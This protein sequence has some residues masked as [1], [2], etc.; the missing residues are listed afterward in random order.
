MI[1][2]KTAVD[3]RLE[4]PTVS[5][6]KGLQTLRISP[7]WSDAEQRKMPSSQPLAALQ[8]F[9]LPFLGLRLFECD[10]SGAT[11]SSERLELLPALHSAHAGDPAQSENHTVEVAQVLG[12]HHKLD[13]GLTVFGLLGIDAANVGVVVGDDGGQLLQHAGAI[14]AVDGDLDRVTLRPAGNLIAHP[15]PLDRDAPVALIQQVLHVG[16]T[17]RMNRNALASR[18]VPDDFFAAN[19]VATSGAI[20]QEV[21]LAFHLE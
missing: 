15:G 14:V 3:T 7:F 13:H 10:H 9:Q 1:N 19:G 8:H 20:N 11:W 6:Q 16:T 17:A 4:R 12:F 5:N 21:V 2:L 18:D